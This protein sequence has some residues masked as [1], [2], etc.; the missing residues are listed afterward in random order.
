[1][2]QWLHCSFPLMPGLI[3]WQAIKLSGSALSAIAVYVIRKGKVNQNLNRTI[4]VSLCSVLLM[5]I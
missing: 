5:L 1:M 4:H 3:Q 2:Y